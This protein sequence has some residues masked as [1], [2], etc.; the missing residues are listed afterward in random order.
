MEQL[1]KA[2]PNDVRFVYRNF[3]IG[4][5]KSNIAVQAA[6][7]A[8]LQG[9]FWEMHDV[10]FDQNTWDTWAAMSM[11][12]FI[13]WVTGKAGDIGLDVA[14]FTSD[15][16]SPAMV[17]KAANAQSAAA[18][19]R[20][21]ATPSLFVLLDGKLYW[22]PADGFP[23]SFFN[24]DAILKLWKLQDQQYKVCPAN[25][26]NTKSDYYATLKTTKGDIE[27]Q[28]YADKAPL[29]VNSFVFLAKAGWYDNVPWHRVIDGFM[30]QTGDPTGTGIGGPGYEFKDEL[31]NGL[32]FDQAG[33][34]GMANSGSNTNGSQFFIT[35]AAQ[36]SLDGKYTVFGQV[37]KGMD[38]VN[39]LIKR[40]PSSDTTLAN[41]DLILSVTVTTR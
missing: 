41:P 35:L 38:V 12:D 21:N 33:M 15:L 16:Q 34:V 22:A 37:T 40:D 13:T 4:H 24:F 11:S 6:E 39:Q 5:E 17:Q 10:L 23:A 19:S 26:I 14:K 2:Y 25:E 36:T 3:P 31:N 29:A 28:L 1:I 18:T 32:N 30:A 9:K 8:G 27:I 20:I 7:A